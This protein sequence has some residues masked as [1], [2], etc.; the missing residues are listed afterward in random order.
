MI[1]RELRHL[2]KVLRKLATT[3]CNI[4][5]VAWRKSITTKSAASVRA[6][7]ANAVNI[8]GPGQC[9]FPPTEKQKLLVLEIMTIDRLTIKIS[10][11]KNLHFI[12]WI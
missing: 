7:H 5:R 10:N 9:I 12:L 4:G 1:L 2:I 6:T 3:D 8:R 11:F